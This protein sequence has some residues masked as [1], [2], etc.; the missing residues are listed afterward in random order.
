MRLDASM[1]PGPGPDRVSADSTL[2]DV[3]EFGLIAMLTPLFAQGEHVL[4]AL[5]RSGPGPG[6]MDA[7]NRM[8]TSGFRS[9]RMRV[10]FE[11]P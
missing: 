6:V 5:T 8:Q 11:T 10:G 1:T 9:A 4:T 7:S 2:A 3:G